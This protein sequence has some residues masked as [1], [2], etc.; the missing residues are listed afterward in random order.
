MVHQDHSEF[1][2]ACDGLRNDTR[3]SRPFNQGTAL[4]SLRIIRVWRNQFHLK[5]NALHLHCEAFLVS[6]KS[7]NVSRDPSDSKTRRSRIDYPQRVPGA[8]TIHPYCGDRTV[9]TQVYRSYRGQRSSKT[10]PINRNLGGLACKKS[11]RWHFGL[12][13]QAQAN[14]QTTL[15][16]EHQSILRRRSWIPQCYEWQTLFR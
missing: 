1:T 8:A 11:R 5:Q 12:R 2:A 10:L 14:A 7:P 9:R 13:Q 16:P 3:S 6:L 15:L 4:T